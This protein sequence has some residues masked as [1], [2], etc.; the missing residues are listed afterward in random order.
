MS[1]VSLALRLVASRLVKGQTWAGD[2]VF[3]SPVDP[4]EEWKARVGEGESLPCIAIYTGKR[5]AEVT[6]KATQGKHAT[7]DLVFNVLLPPTPILVG[8]ML[9]MSTSNTGGATAMDL[10]SRQVEA[11]FRF[12]PQPWRSVW[13]IFVLSVLDVESRPLLF[14]IEAGNQVPCLEVI[15]TLKTIPDPDFGV[16]LLPGW[17]ALKDAMSS[18]PDYADHAE[19]IAGFITGP[20][21]LPD[22]RKVQA[23]LG[24][25]DAAVRSIGISPADADQVEDPALLLSGTFTRDPDL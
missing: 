9:E 17:Q 16:E 6:G 8:D 11:A 23:A 7:I 3:N 25:S 1:L 10:I 15:Y 2:M 4:L 14:Q 12:G 5:K 21:G 24:L 22:W 20:E 19:L 13:D 18:D